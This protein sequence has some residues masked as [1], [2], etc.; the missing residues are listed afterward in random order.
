MKKN[1]MSKMRPLSI[2][3]LALIAGTTLFAQTKTKPVISNYSFK[4]KVGGLKDVDVYLGF[5]YGEKKFIKD[6]AHVNQNG[7]VEFTGKDTLQGGIY[8]FVTPRK[9][10]FEFVVNETK[11]QMETDTVDMVGHMNV[12]TSNENKVWYGYMKTIGEKQKELQPLKDIVNRKDIDKTSKEYTDAEAKIKTLTDQINAFRDDQ[13]KKAPDML[14]SKVFKAMKDIDLPVAKT[15]EDSIALPH[16]FKS[17]F[18]DNIDLTD[19]RLIRTPVL[20]SKLVY[21]FEKVIYQIPDSCIAAVD[22]I[23]ARATPEPEMFK[24]ICHHLTYSFERSQIMCMDAVFVHIIDTYYKTNRA[25]WVDQKTL[26]KMYER[27]DKL[28]PILCGKKVEDIILPDT[29]GTAWHGLY[30]LKGDY[31]IL[32][33]WDATC[34][35]CKKTTPV[36][37]DLYKEYLKPNGIEIF[38]VEGEL[39]DAEWKK[40]TKEHNLPWVNVSDNPEINTHPEKYI[41]ELK[42]TTLASLNFRHTFDL[43]SYPVLFILDKDKKIIAKK[44]GVEQVK[45]FLDKYRSSKSGKQNEQ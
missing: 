11:I 2:L 5:H 36:L 8:L 17:H 24:F 12:K 21:Y 39:E 34:S 7:E 6:T 25:K 42:K 1:I 29:S 3:V 20:E 16:Y 23:L 14:V 37:I 35:H 30:E 40:Y 44:L 38:G 13:I 27:A 15:K 33:F 19:N 45:E 28:R 41:I 31:T 43:Y 18:W 26:D 32:Y 10:F 22:W 9:N 4:F